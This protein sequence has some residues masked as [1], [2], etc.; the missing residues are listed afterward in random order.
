MAT[1]EKTFQKTVVIN[2]AIPGSGKT[3]I[4]RCIK[5]TLESRGI[6]VSIH[7]TDDYFLTET[8]AYQFDL[9]KLAENHAKNLQSFQQAI[10]RRT[11]LVICDN[12]NLA[13]WEAD[14]YAT[15]ARAHHY[16]IIIINYVPRELVKHLAVQQVTNEKMDAHNIPEKELVEMMKRYHKYHNYLDRFLPSCNNSDYAFSWSNEKLAMTPTDEPI[17]NYDYDHLLIV[18]PNEFHRAKKDIPRKILA[19]ITGEKMTQKSIQDERFL[20]LESYL[21]ETLPNFKKK[22][23]ENTQLGSKKCD[24]LIS[25]LGFSPE[26]TVLATAA[27][28]PKE[29]IVITS[30]EALEQGHYKLLDDMIRKFN[31]LESRLMRYE[32]LN[33]LNP[34]QIYASVARHAN[35][36]NVFVDIT[37]GTKIMTAAAAQAAWENNA[38]SCY[39]HSKFDNRKKLPVSGTEQLLLLENPSE[40]KAKAWRNKGIDAWKSRNFSMARD[41]FETSEQLNPDP[42][43]DEIA[44]QLCTF[45]E[46]L[47]NFDVKKLEEPLKEI[48]KTIAKTAMEKI[49]KRNNFR[50]QLQN[51]IEL[52]DKPDPLADSNTKIAAFLSLAQ[53]YSKLGRYEFAGLLAYRAIEELVD[54]GLRQ[55]SKEGN[56]DRKE[57]KYENLTDNFKELEEKFLDLCGNRLPPRVALAD[58]YAL[59]I[60]LKPEQYENVFEGEKMKPARVL[61]KISGICSSRNQSILAHG[62]NPLGETNFQAINNLAKSIYKIITKEDITPLIEK[63]TPP[64]LGELIEQPN[65]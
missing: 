30:D 23:Q 8:R 31:L 20:K 60:I 16:Q 14:P 46:Y 59:L 45:Y 24:L 48:K 22:C 26:T 32:N 65:A 56:F 25:L 39:I 6:T 36:Q 64:R 1:S 29:L 34:Q 50:I 12:T 9:Y 18:Q 61:K 7:S 43:F 57:P 28:Q 49:L 41:A 53:E 33:I 10:D 42:S 38:Q 58:G 19:M 52:F 47:F 5:E 11:D 44:Q 17:K 40:A 35:K 13:P 3:T 27:L 37:G 55:L 51:L 2:R 62:N 54:V 21:K 4:S 63:I 15:Y